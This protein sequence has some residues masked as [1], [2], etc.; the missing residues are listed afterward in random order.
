MFNIDYSDYSDC[1]TPHQ[2]FAL[3]HGSAS[4]MH[5]TIGTRLRQL[6]TIVTTGCRWWMMDQ[7]WSNGNASKRWTQVPAVL[8]VSCKHPITFRM[9]S[10]LEN[11]NCSSFFS[12]TCK[13]RDTHTWCVFHCKIP[14]G[15]VCA[16]RLGGQI[17]HARWFSH[18]Q[19]PWKKGYVYN[20]NFWFL[21]WLI[22][23]WYSMNIPLLS[24]YWCRISQMPWFPV[25]SWHRLGTGG[26]SQPNLRSS[27]RVGLWRRGDLRC[28]ILGGVG[29][30]KNG[31]N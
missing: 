5:G 14:F 16:K 29:M 1:P 8:F 19:T 24:H 7:T 22:F 27:C 31:V 2:R 15:N 26:L 4:E 20:C 12:R 30:S 18:L 17:Y 23:H 6:F 21:G 11:L 25:Q 13:S 10:H 28:L 3:C 9:Q